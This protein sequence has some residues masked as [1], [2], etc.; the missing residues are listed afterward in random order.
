MATE[1][2]EPAEAARRIL[3]ERYAGAA[4]LFL[5]G[6]VVRGEGTPSSDLDLVVVYER[7]PNAYREAFVYEGWPVE[8][9]VHDPATLRSFFQSDS[10]EGIPSILCMVR[11][12]VEI[13]AP[14]PLSAELKAEAAA[15]IEAGPP[16]WDDEHV[17]NVRYWLTDCVDDLRH[18]RSDE[19]LV[20]TGAQL[21]E[22]AADFFLRSRGLW[23]ARRKMI[24]RRLRETDPDFAARFG[25]AFD[26]LFIEKR[27]DE[28]IALVADML[29]PHGGF[30]F[31]GY[32]RD[33]PPPS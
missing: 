9:F 18:P 1:R 13:P 31:D 6:S 3:G 5:A 21:Y 27:Q 24:P 20:A 11:E 4:V 29:A 17:G 30:L 23:S 14:S 19:E 32:R 28:A 15:L 33:A 16:A 26:A 12:G 25:R 10:R 8:A 2:L 22:L 7:V